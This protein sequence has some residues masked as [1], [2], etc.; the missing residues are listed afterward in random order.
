MSTE[1]LPI[2]VKTYDFILWTMNHTA[3]FPKSARFSL[4]V[5]IENNLLEMLRAVMAANRLRDK[6]AMLEQADRHLEHARILMRMS[7]DL[8]YLNISSYEHAALSMDEIG[9]M[10]G[11]WL[12]QQ[13]AAGGRG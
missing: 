8:R 13:K 12:K 9:R 2:F 4:A 6:A 5:R 11:G 1:N 3:K 10:L 7:K